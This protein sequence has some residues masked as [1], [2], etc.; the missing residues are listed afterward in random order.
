M[1]GRERRGGGEGGSCV[2]DMSDGQWASNL[3]SGSVMS[4]GCHLCSSWSNFV[5][6]IASKRFVFQLSKALF[7]KVG[8]SFWMVLIR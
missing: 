3:R 7:T 2:L 4:L 8:P 1:E 5:H 6:D